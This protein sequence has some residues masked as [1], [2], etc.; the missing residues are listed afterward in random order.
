M[1]PEAVARKKVGDLTD[2]QGNLA[3]F[4]VDVH[5]RPGEI[6]RLGVCQRGGKGK[7]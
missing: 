5:L 4:Y 3:P 2:G 6:E 1:N 7:Q